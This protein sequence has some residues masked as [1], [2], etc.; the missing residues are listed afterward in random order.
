MIVLERPDQLDAE[1]YRRIVLEH[2]AVAVAPAL[3]EAVDGARA[4][5]LAQLASGATAYGVNTSLGYLAG[6]R[7]DP[8]EQRAFQRSILLRGAGQGPPLAPAVVRGALLIRL[9]GFLTGWAGVSAALCR[10]IAD[11]LNDDWAPSVPSRGVTSAGEVIA[12]SHLFQTFVGAGAVIEDGA[13]VSAAEALA[14]RAV[15]PYE[16]DVKEGIALVNG[17][18]LAPAL[19]AWLATRCRALLDHATLAGAL[20]AALAGGSPRPYSRRIGRL[21]G[22]PGQDRVHAQLAQLHAG[23]AD[24]ADRPQSPVSFRVLPQVHGAVHELVDAIEAQVARELRAVTDSPLYL[25]ADGDEPAGF[26]PSGN[27]HSQALSF[28]LDALAIGFAQVGNL[29]EKRLHRLLD[30]RFSGLADQ[31]ASDPGRQ[32]GLIFAHKSAL[33]FVAENR[34]LAAPASVHSLDSSA[35]QEDFQAFTFLAAE[36][37]GRLLDNLELILAAELVAIRQARHL[38]ATALPPPL[39][40]VVERL[41]ARVAPLDEDRPL[42]DDLERVRALIRSGGIAGWQESTTSDQAHP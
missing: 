38:H 25:G 36:Q 5:M 37:L 41:A 35:G 31:L 12:L 17:A 42:S 24:W 15:A 29:S 10:F 11:R 7:I 13:T 21:K 9:A 27:F 6:T 28:A 23:E 16:P 18:P 8:D 26:Y 2:E 22:D 39:E 33:G 4:R 20:T 32:T 30:R 3:L 40:T 19:A 1:Q 14:R 34:L